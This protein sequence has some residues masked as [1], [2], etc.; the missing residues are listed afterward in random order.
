MVF[1]QDEQIADHV[2]VSAL[3]RFK[4]QCATQERSLYRSGEGLDG[5]LVAM[6]TT[7][8]TSGSYENFWRHAE[9]FHFVRRA[10]SNLHQPAHRGLRAESARRS[11]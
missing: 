4:T 3:L 10:I 1:H 9:R 11:S 6:K 5:S 8:C 2:C 7:A